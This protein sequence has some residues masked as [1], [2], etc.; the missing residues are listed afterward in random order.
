MEAMH[1]DD[2]DDD[3]DDA[4]PLIPIQMVHDGL[5]FCMSVYALFKPT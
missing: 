2:D 3:D 1:S 5:F 4:E